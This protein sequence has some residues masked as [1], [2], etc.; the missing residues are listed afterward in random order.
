MVTPPASKATG[1]NSEGTK[2]TNKKTAKYKIINILESFILNTILSI[3]IAK[4]I[5]TPIATAIIKTILG[6]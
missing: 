3:D 6:T 2:K 4:N 5:P 1:K